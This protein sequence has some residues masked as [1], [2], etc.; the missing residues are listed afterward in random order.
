V[1]QTY[2]K[3]K[4]SWSGL[5]HGG[6]CRVR[7]G[8]LEVCRPALA[9]TFSGR[10]EF[11]LALGKDVL[12]MALEFILGGQ[13]ADGAIEANRIVMGDVVADHPLGVFQ[14]ERGFGSDRFA[15]Q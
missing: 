1:A 10:L 9:T 3:A 4:N 2:T 6:A 12:G 5:L 14:G 8:P 15:F 13:V 7:G 11:R